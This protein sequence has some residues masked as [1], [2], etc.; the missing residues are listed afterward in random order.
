MI[1]HLGSCRCSW[2]GCMLDWLGLLA[3]AINVQLCTL[4]YIFFRG[5]YQ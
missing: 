1:F 3:I 2:I 4:A 5:S